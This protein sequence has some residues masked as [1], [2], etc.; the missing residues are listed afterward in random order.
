MPDGTD[1]IV[2][3]YAPLFLPPPVDDDEREVEKF[4]RDPSIDAAEIL[5]GSPKNIG[6]R[7][8]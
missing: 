2:A 8:P 5:R 6:Y 4:R 1:S 7:L 3:S